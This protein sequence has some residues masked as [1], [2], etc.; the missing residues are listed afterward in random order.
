MNDTKNILIAWLSSTTSV[1]AAIE[2]RE[3]ITI[4][5][6]IVLP[7]LFFTIGKTV[8]VLVQVYLKNKEK[9]E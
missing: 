6:A 4:V 7:V 3:L 9:K 8:D 2:Y 1:L 5:S